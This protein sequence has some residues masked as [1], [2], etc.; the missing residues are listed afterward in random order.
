[1]KFDIKTRHSPTQVLLTVTVATP[2]VVRIL[3]F[4]RDFPKTILFD[5]TALNNGSDQCLVKMPLTGKAI[6]LMVINNSPSATDNDAGITVSKKVSKLKRE[7]TESQIHDPYF[8]EFVKFAEQFSY[9]AQYLPTGKTYESAHK[10]YA[11]KY[12]DTIMSKDGTPMTTPAR[13]KM[14]SGFIEFSKNR[15]A[16]MSVP[17]ILAVA[18]HEFSHNF[19]NTNEESEEEAD[20]NSL[21]TYLG[22]GFPLVEAYKA[23]DN[24]YQYTNTELNRQR[25]SKVTQLLLD[26]SKEFPYAA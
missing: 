7:L 12:V 3:A 9:N 16:D 17:A 8:R 1:M 26:Y 4:D 23:W 5:R 15:L 25:S 21:I 11:I 13:I 2:T 24:I 6:S 22:L 19:L 10:H 20:L 18:L 14:D